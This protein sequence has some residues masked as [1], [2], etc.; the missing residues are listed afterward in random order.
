M[1]LSLFNHLHVK[2]TIKCHLWTL[3]QIAV[4]LLGDSLRCL[5]NQNITK[6]TDLY[7]WP[8]FFYCGTKFKNKL[9]C[10]NVETQW[11]GWERFQFCF[12]FFQSDETASSF[13]S[14]PCFIYFNLHLSENGQLHTLQREGGG[15]QTCL[16]RDSA[17]PRHPSTCRFPNLFCFY[18]LSFFILTVKMWLEA[19]HNTYPLFHFP[20]PSLFFFCCFLF[21]PCSCKV[22]VFHKKLKHY[23]QSE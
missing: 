20:S 23:Y 21:L 16:N 1:A 12:V 17:S 2:L 7:F 19:F 4:G 8:F 3:S 13:H 15:V 5:D 6:N 10:F 18:F 11:R 22:L 14:I 9:F